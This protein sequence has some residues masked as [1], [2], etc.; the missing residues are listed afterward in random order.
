VHDVTN[1]V[2]SVAPEV[3]APGNDRILARDRPVGFVRRVV[4]GWNIETRIGVAIVAVLVLAAILAPVITRSNPDAINILHAQRPPSLAHPFGT[5]YV[6]RDVLARTLYGA[7]IDLLVVFLVTYIGLI[8]GVLAGTLAG[9]HGGLIDGLV[10]RA[11]DC[12]IAFPFIILVLIVITLTG[13]GLRGIAIG[14]ILVGWALYARLARS[15]MLSLREEP[16]MLATRSLGYTNRRA[17][18]RHALPNV[19]RSCL[20]YSTVD[21]LVNLLVIAS[22]SYLGFGPQEP[23]PDLGALI[24]GGQPYLLTAWWIT[25]LPGLFVV[26]FGFGVSL[27]GD[28]LSHGDVT[29]GVR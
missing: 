29:V 6:G 22:M 20:V 21:I 18:L 15:E 3:A 26:L 14:I 23:R 19:V 24:A 11:A 8:V 13:S 27:I 17:I 12:A 1:P 25:T 4:R 9:F 7:R 28:G 2:S 10:G 5:D 16:F